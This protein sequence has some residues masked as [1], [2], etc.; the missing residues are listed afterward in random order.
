MTTFT[1]NIRIA[2]KNPETRWFAPHDL[3]EDLLLTPASW[4]ERLTFRGKRKKRRLAFYPGSY[5]QKLILVMHVL[6]FIACFP[7]ILLILQASQKQNFLLVWLTC[8][9]MLGAIGA[10]LVRIIRTR[11]KRSILE[12]ELLSINTCAII[13]L[14][15]VVAHFRTLANLGLNSDQRLDNYQNYTAELVKQAESLRDSFP[16]IY[17]WLEDPANA[18]KLRS[19]IS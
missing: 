12:S 10:I 18:K 8:V 1:K 2:H 19:Q 6:A 3:E 4:F 11:A 5:F 16:F 13:W 7:L 15:V 14:A 9:V 17:D